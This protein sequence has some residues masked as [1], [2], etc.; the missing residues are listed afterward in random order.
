MLPK[1]V[2]WYFLVAVLRAAVRGVGGGSEALGIS[3]DGVIWVEVEC[4]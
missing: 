3:C 4:C 2:G 1:N